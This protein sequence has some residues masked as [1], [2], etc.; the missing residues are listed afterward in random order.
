M[1]SAA[2]ATSISAGE[3]PSTQDSAGASV[4]RKDGVEKVVD[5]DEEDAAMEDDDAALEDDDAALED[6]GE[7]DG[8]EDSGT[9]AAGGSAGSIP[10]RHYVLTPHT[11]R[12][13]VDITFGAWPA[14]STGKCMGCSA[15]IPL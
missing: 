10:R 1:P 14:G 4:Q 9:A 7:T 12:V 3:P 13:M 6:G 8:E 2:G 15:M 5:G 11:T